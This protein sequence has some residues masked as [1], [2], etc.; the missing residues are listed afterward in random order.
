MNQL[1]FQANALRLREA[2][3]MDHA[4]YFPSNMVISI[5]ILARRKITINSGVQQQVIMT[6]IRNGEI[7][8]CNSFSLFSPYSGISR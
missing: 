8:V 5:I 7:V 3:E 6:K 1:F 2:L 4:A